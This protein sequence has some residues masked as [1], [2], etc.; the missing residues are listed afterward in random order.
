MDDGSNQRIDAI[1]N[2][3]ERIYAILCII[4]FF[5]ALGVAGFF[6]TRHQH[7]ARDLETLKQE[8]VAIGYAKD[9]S[10]LGWGWVVKGDTDG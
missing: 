6:Y 7:V 5:L 2:L 10:V 8:A 1:Y 9:D 4:T 3:M